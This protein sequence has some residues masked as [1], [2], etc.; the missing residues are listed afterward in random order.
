[1]L[2]TGTRRSRKTPTVHSETRLLL[3]DLLDKAASSGMVCFRSEFDECTSGDLTTIHSHSVG[4]GAVVSEHHFCMFALHFCTASCITST[5]T[6]VQVVLRGRR[7]E[8]DC[9]LGHGQERR[10]RRMCI[11]MNIPTRFVLHEDV[12]NDI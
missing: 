1:M 7:P 2:V 6:L 10:R 5:A 3:A 8:E 4:V 9:I 11:A 12:L